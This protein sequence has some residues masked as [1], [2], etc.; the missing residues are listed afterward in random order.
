MPKASLQFAAEI[1][2][3]GGVDIVGKRKRLVDRLDAVFLGVARIADVRLFAGDKNLAGVALVGAREHLDQRRL[4]GAVV[5]EQADH[6]A[7]KEIEACMVDGPDAA[8][9]DGDVAHLD[10]RCLGHGF[11]PHFTRRR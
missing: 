8:E 5:A 4:S 9:G 6:L 11:L 10:Q 2:I 7:W 1:E 3:G